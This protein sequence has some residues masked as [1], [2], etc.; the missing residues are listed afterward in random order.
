MSWQEYLQ[1]KSYAYF[2]SDS[3]TVGN[4]WYGSGSQPVTQAC[5]IDL[6]LSPIYCIKTIKVLPHYDIT[7]KMMVHR[8]YVAG[9][10]ALGCK[11]LGTTVAK[12]I[13]YFLYSHVTYE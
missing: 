8:L 7:H 2:K 1:K 12:D 6:A 3:K 11:R 4:I 13:S 9:K 10:V 5:I